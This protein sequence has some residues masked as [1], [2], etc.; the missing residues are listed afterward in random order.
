MDKEG[1]RPPDHDPF[2]RLQEIIPRDAVKA[3]MLRA[4]PRNY[5]DLWK[6][7]EDYYSIIEGFAEGDKVGRKGGAVGGGG[8]AGGG[9]GVGGGKQASKDSVY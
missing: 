3:C 2:H 4:H 1:I 8:G 7:L 9:G 5:Q 6:E